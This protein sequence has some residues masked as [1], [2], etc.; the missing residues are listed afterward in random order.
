MDKPGVEKKIKIAKPPECHLNHSF[1]RWLIKIIN[2]NKYI[3]SNNTINIKLLLDKYKTK[4]RLGES[5]SMIVTRRSV[6]KVV[7]ESV[8]TYWNFVGKLIVDALSIDPVG[9][10]TIRHGVNANRYNG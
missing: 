3:N 5:H 2:N 9:R 8:H 7:S 1:G 10:D 4:E 6:I